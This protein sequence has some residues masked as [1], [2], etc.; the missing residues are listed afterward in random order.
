MG[1][2]YEVHAW[3]KHAD[4]GY[5]YVNVYEGSSLIGAIRAARKA[6]RTSGCVRLEW[7]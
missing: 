3:T 5:S 7:R 2:K 6:K 1:W 4:G